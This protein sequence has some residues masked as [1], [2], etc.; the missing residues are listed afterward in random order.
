MDLTK[1]IIE[2]YFNEMD[3]F[4][5][6][7]LLEVNDSREVWDHSNEFN[8]GYSGSGPA[9]ASLAILMFL[10]CDNVST[11]V[12]LHQQFKRDFVSKWKEGE[13]FKV[14]IDFQEWYD[15]LKQY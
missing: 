10:L 7:M 4:V 5:N 3:I 1:V 2:G 13:D 15:K 14:E 8:W 12:R 11:A 6:G 9:Q